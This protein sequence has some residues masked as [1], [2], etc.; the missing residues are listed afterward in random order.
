MGSIFFFSRFW[1]EKTVGIFVPMI[2]MTF[3]NRRELVQAI[4][5]RVQVAAA[6]GEEV[7]AINRILSRP[8]SARRMSS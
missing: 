4:S 7:S 8:D 1:D 5:G 2:Q 6:L 3:S